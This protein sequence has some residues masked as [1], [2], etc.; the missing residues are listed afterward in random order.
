MI[1]KNGKT[2][3]RQGA[4]RPKVQLDEKKLEALAQINCT[5]EEMAEIMECGIST[6][7]ANYQHIIKRGRANLKM[8][9]KR[10][11]Y[12]IAMKGNV[13]MLIF[14]GKVLLKQREDELFA[15]I[16]ELPEF[17]EMSNE[18]LDAFIDKNNH[19]TK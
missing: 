11:Q 6:L 14:L 18:E 8:S 9:L 5:L 10:K 17:A 15:D 4:G 7:Q 1:N 16:P 19:I 3:K 12:E 13:T 2:T